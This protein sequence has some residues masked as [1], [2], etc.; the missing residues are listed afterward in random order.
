M[1][2][3]DL[4]PHCVSGVYMLYHSDYEQWQFG[5]LSAL[6]E[7]SLALEGGYEELW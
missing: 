4:L 3:L 5:K 6:R 2:I 7:A 1:G